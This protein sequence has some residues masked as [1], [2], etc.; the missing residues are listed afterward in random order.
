MNKLITIAK[1]LLVS[2]ISMFFVVSCTACV[3]VVSIYNS[4]VNAEVRNDEGELI[5]KKKYPLKN[6]DINITEDDVI[7]NGDTLPK[8]K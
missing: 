5:F 4:D 8:H 1:H 2:V 3:A 6:L 7:I